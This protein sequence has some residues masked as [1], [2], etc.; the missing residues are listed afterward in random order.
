MF[1][2]VG[3]FSIIG[4]F[5]LQ[6]NAT[7]AEVLFPAIAITLLVWLV[8]VFL[9]A[10]YVKAYIRRYYYD[11]NENFV[12]I[13]KG[14]FA[15]AEIHVQYSKIQDVYVDQDILDRIMGL[16]DVHIASATAASAIEA[17]I[18]G[19]EK[20]SSDGLK[21][22]LL[23]KIQG[24]STSVSQTP[25][26]GSAS[27]TPLAVHL[28][29]EV[30]S[31]TYPIVGQWLFLQAIGSLVFA[32]FVGGAIVFYFIAPGEH[33]DTSTLTAL[34][35]SG[36]QVF[37]VWLILSLFVF[38]ISFVYQV[39]WKDTFSF[40]FLPEYIVLQKG[41]I[42][43]QETHLPYRSVQDV[44]V[45]QGIIERMFGLATVRIENAAASQMVGK[46]MVSSGLRMP[47]Q[48]LEKANKLSEI[49]RNITLT[50]NSS[51]TGL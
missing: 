48:T 11:A 39:L 29:E 15:P 26:Q 42:A 27:A 3:V 44:A 2:I 23:G 17:H 16:Y 33:S 31:K 34:G 1:F 45:S 36:N 7:I 41:V 24:V 20:V 30:S 25:T 19:V 43:R 8:L 22:L 49:V 28:T 32:L 40:S 5:A 38:I 18:D 50:K 10:W 35:F 37:V 9:Y 47:G 51:Q 13:K 12:T 21:D 4:L 6:L 14:V 46:K